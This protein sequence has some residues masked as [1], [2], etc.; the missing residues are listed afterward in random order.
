MA[1]DTLIFIKNLSQ[2][3]FYSVCVYC[4]LILI[5]WPL[6]PQD[7]GKAYDL[8]GDVDEALIF[9]R[10]IFHKPGPQIF[11]MGASHSNHFESLMVAEHL[12]ASVT[13][14]N[15]WMGGAN[16]SLMS[17]LSDILLEKIPNS[18]L[19]KMVVVLSIW[20]GSFTD[21]DTRYPGTRNPID[22][23][24]LRY[25]I[26]YENLNGHITARVGPKWFPYL[27]TLY[28]P[29]RAINNT[30]NKLRPARAPKA[31]GIGEGRASIEFNNEDQ[32]R[33]F[34]QFDE[35]MGYKN[36]RISEEQ[37][38]VFFEL[39]S[40]LTRKKVNVLIVDMG[41]P[42]WHSQ[43]SDF[44]KTYESKKHVILELINNSKYLHYLNLQ[45]LNDPMDFNDP[46]HAKYVTY[47]IWSK[48][49]G[50]KLDHILKINK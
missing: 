16:V 3:I 36:G 21:N 28:M 30:V 11:I 43:G 9:S 27:A 31:I 13:I 7:K 12:P 14:H 2:I 15:L 25:K 46:T 8:H 35:S 44:H 20:Y 38:N 39:T 19:D 10:K 29:Q 42:S 34:Q 37:F 33:F 4:V 22:L 40:R 1:S 50:D 47:P 48:R 17:S 6:A 24:K 32:K 18:Q 23:L 49:L 41:I 5:S 26:L 45:D